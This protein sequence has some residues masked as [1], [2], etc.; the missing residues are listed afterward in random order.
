MKLQEL[1]NPERYDAISYDHSGKTY[2]GYVTKVEDDYI[3]ARV[4][5]QSMYRKNVHDEPVWNTVILYK[6]V[7]RGLNVQFWFDGQGCDNSAIGSSG[8][9]ESLAECVGA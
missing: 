2:D 9:C 8:Y 7:F 3:E 1:L 5:L 4:S 6:Q